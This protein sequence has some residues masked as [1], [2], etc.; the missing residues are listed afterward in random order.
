MVYSVVVRIGRRIAADARN[1]SNLFVTV[2]LIQVRRDDPVPTALLFKS[3]LPGAIFDHNNG[4]DKTV[5]SCKM[6]DGRFFFPFF[7]FPSFARGACKSRSNFAILARTGRTSGK[8]HE[9]RPYRLRGPASN[10]EAEFSRERTTHASRSRD[11]CH[12]DRTSKRFS[13]RAYRAKYPREKYPERNTG[14]NLEK[15]ERILEHPV[16]SILI[17]L[18]HSV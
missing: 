8:L 2:G 11:D 6:H 1:A 9:R 13:I 14:F 17:T 3:Y 10:S 4:I 7:S 15:T 5:P 12:V 16:A 18:T